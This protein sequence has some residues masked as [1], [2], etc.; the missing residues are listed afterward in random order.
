MTGVAT[1]LKM[2]ALV[3]WV[4]GSSNHLMTTIG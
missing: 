3:V 4:L 2:F 1:L